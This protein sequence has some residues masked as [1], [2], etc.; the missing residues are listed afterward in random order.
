MV[1]LP[2]WRVRAVPLKAPGG[3]GWRVPMLKSAQEGGST[4]R[5]IYGQWET[6]V[7]LGNEKQLLFDAQENG[8]E[9]QLVGL[10]VKPSQRYARRRQQVVV[11]RPF[12]LR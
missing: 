7:H 1:G 3:S 6:H 9:S 2:A 10:L 12:F 5:E 11:T 8:I 4:Q